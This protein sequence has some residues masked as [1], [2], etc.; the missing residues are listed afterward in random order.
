M[1]CT[2]RLGGLGVLGVW[3]CLCGFELIHHEEAPRN[4]PLC[5][6]RFPTLLAVRDGRM[7]Y[8]FVKKT[9]KRPKTLEAN[10]KTDIRNSE[11]L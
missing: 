4:L 1:F 6:L 5:C 2:S 8:R 10:F 9:A 3:E 11:I 7:A